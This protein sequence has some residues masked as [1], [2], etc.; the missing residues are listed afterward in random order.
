MPTL[1][2]MSAG[3]APDALL[4]PCLPVARDEGPGVSPSLGRPASIATFGARRPTAVQDEHILLSF[5]FTP[6]HKG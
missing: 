6:A 3:G 2:A 1:V 4:G 5:Q